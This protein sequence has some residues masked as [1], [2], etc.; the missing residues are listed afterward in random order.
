MRSKK[1]YISIEAIVISAVILA[2]GVYT[3][4]QII[5]VN[6]MVIDKIVNIQEIEGEYIKL[7]KPIIDN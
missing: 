1:G 3:S 2:L 5:D 6:K 4:R 7:L